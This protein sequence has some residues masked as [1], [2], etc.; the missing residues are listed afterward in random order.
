[1]IPWKGL[2]LY[3]VT[4][5]DQTHDQESGRTFTK[6]SLLGPRITFDYPALMVFFLEKTRSH[7]LHFR[8]R[9]LGLG[10]G[11]SLLVMNIVV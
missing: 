6:L 11:L 7:F 3:H 2:F 1:M 10:L 8:T 4:S 9:L 5:R